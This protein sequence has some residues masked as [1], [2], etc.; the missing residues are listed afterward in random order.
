MVNRHAAA[1]LLLT[2]VNSNLP[3]KSALWNSVKAQLSYVVEHF[4]PA[5]QPE[6]Q[7]MRLQCPVAW[8]EASLSESG[9]R[10]FTGCIQKY[11]AARGQSSAVR[12]PALKAWPKSS[13]SFSA[14]EL[15]SVERAIVKGQLKPY[16][17]APAVY[18]SIDLAVVNAKFR[19]QWL[20]HTQTMAMQ[21][22]VGWLD[23]IG[24]PAPIHDT[25]TMG[26]VRN[27]D[28]SEWAELGAVLRA[29]QTAAI[30]SAGNSRA[31]RLACL[32]EL[33]N[34]QAI[35]AYLAYAMVTVGR[36]L[37][38]TTEMHLSAD[39]LWLADKTNGQYQ[40]RKWFQ[41]EPK[42]PSVSGYL[43]QMAAIGKSV[44]VIQAIAENQ[45]VPVLIVE[46][47]STFP[48]CVCPAVNG[49][50]VRRLT[51]NAF[52]RLAQGLRLPADA[53]EVLNR[54]RHHFAT[55]A[56]QEMHESIRSEILGHKYPGE[57][58]FGLES[59]VAGK[60]VVLPSAV[61]ADWF[62]QSGWRVLSVP[63]KRYLT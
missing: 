5:G 21:G 6:P 15:D 40:E 18:R 20:S 33:T 11:D 22:H 58:V 44:D 45:D 51:A 19:R 39:A 43:M 14:F 10:L 27:A 24:L 60:P 56:P 49:F 36:E 30:R 29:N 4:E 34:L 61:L 57:D 48:R 54:I 52:R 59:A 25:V 55:V 3:R 23:Q 41:F 16:R 47:Q 13:S 62:A 38:D 28:L 2:R 42:D 12:L 31:K 26:S 37:K 1:A 53:L 17:T 7:V 32:V 63:V 35:N 46:H 50:E 9:K 8:I